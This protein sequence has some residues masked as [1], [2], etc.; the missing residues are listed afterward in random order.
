MEYVAIGHLRHDKRYSRASNCVYS[1]ST[2]HDAPGVPPSRAD[3]TST[4]APWPSASPCWQARESFC[5]ANSRQLLSAE[6][7]LLSLFRFASWLAVIGCAL[8]ASCAGT[9]VHEERSEFSHIRVVDSGGQ[10]ALYF[11]GSSGVEVVETLMDLRHPEILQHAYSRTAMASLLYVPQPSSCLL[12]GLGGGAI[13]RFLDHHFPQ[14]QLDVV[15]I[16]PVVVRVA[17]EHFGTTESQRTRIHVADGREFLE[18]GGA[19]YD[20]ILIDAHLHPEVRTDGAGHPLSLQGEAFYRSVRAR[21]KPGGIAMF[22]LIAGRDAEAYLASIRA[23]FASADVYRPKETGNILV[24]VSPD[25]A[26]ADEAA[27]RLR[28]RELDT[29]GGHG[30]LFEQLLAARGQP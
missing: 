27:L 10:R 1:R 6:I 3:F 16:D 20:L 5:A 8:L 26:L 21:L 14:L 28:A 11:L 25:R 30:F 29:H 15:E 2:I 24:F 12:I 7:V 13:V 18:R 17:R 9:L 23:A 19:R 22:N 4:G